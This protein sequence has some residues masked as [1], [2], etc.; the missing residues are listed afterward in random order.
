[1]QEKNAK[2]IEQLKQRL[3][4]AVEHLKFTTHAA[5]Y[6]YKPDVKLNKNMTPTFYFTLTYEGDLELIEKCKSAMEFLAKISAE[7]EQ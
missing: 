7:K 6:L 2:E 1:M 3:E 5:E 4:I